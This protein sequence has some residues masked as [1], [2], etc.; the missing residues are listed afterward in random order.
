MKSLQ[1]MD[2]HMAK[3]P[4]DHF[5]EPL[6]L[7]YDLYLRLGPDHFVQIGRNGTHSHVHQ[8]KAFGSDLVPCFFVHRGEYGSYVDQT[9]LQAQAAVLAEQDSFARARAVKKAM[10]AV[11]EQIRTS[12]F[13]NQSWENT[14]ELSGLLNRLITEKPN[15]MSLMIELEKL[16]E[17]HARHAVAVAITALMVGQELKLSAEKMEILGAG[18]LLHDIGMIKIPIEIAQK[19]LV[20]M[21][22]EELRIYKTHPHEGAQMLRE[23][24]HVPSEVLLMAYEHHE[25]ELGTGYPRELEKDKIHP[26]TKIVSL[27]DHFCELTLGDA[28]HQ[29]FLSASAAVNTIANVEGHPYDINAL[30]ALEHLVVRP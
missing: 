29:D 27:A 9:M 12:G 18:A 26:L 19:R 3:V 6:A 11:L 20:L 14:K 4:K 25:N 13:Q 28:Q 5:A 1:I 17:L 7:P 21:T 15:L 23:C 22:P 24:S 8:L 10:F 30:K 16:G 2:E